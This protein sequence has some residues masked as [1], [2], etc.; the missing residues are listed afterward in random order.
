[1]RHFNVGTQLNGIGSL[2]IGQVDQEAAAAREQ[3]ML[4]S[5]ECIDNTAADTIT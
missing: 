3:Q 5:L 1:M 4:C 2:L